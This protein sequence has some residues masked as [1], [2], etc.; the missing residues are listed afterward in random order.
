MPQRIWSRNPKASHSWFGNFPYKDSF[1]KKHPTECNGGKPWLAFLVGY[2]L[3]P[4]L[5]FEAVHLT[6]PPTSLVSFDVWYPRR[7]FSNHIWVSTISRNRSTTSTSLAISDGDNFKR[8]AVYY[9]L[10]LLVSIAVGLLRV[11]TISGQSCCLASLYCLIASNS[12]S[13]SFN[14]FVALSMN[15]KI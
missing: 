11:T 8:D 15:A 1:E 7:R 6:L 12:A 9:Q 3:L 2:R 4:S 13:D 14:M 5:S 10:V